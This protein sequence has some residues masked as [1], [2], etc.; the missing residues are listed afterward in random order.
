M[1][2]LS[3]TDLSNLT[4]KQMTIDQKAEMKRRLDLFVRSLNVAK[5]EVP[6]GKSTKPAKWNPGAKPKQSGRSAAPPR[7]S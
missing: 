3:Q 6:V 1:S 4:L 7:R 5:V 2:D